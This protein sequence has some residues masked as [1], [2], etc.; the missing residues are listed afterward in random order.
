MYTEFLDKVM[1]AEQCLFE[2]LGEAHHFPAGSQLTA[3][4]LWSHAMFLP[5]QELIKPANTFLAKRAASS[6]CFS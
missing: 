1:G 6:G 4:M 5:C 3:A 2:F